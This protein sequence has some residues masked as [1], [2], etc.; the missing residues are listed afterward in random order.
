[1]HPDAKAAKLKDIAMHPE[2]VPHACC[3]TGSGSEKSATAPAGSAS[4]TAPKLYVCNALN[5]ID[6][7]TYV[8]YVGP[9]CIGI[10]DTTFRF[11]NPETGCFTPFISHNQAYY[12]YTDKPSRRTSVW[13]DC[14]DGNKSSKPRSK[15]SATV[16][17]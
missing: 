15:G 5:R 4:V 2:K 14:G 3:C 17:L 7:K 11:V 1:M 8:E 13:R 10:P 16:V 6:E 9:D 12:L